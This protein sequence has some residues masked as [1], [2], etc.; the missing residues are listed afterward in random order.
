[1]T[2]AALDENTRKI[3]DAFIAELHDELVQADVLPIDAPFIAK[4]NGGELSRE[5]ITRWARQFYLTVREAPRSIGNQYVNCPD[6]ALKVEIAESIYEEE[7]G[8]I[9]GTKNHAELFRQFLRALG[10]DDDEADRTEPG[11]IAA[12]MMAREVPFKQSEE[13]FYDGLALSGLVGEG[14]MAKIAETLFHAFQKSPYNF[15]PHDLEW[16]SVHGEAD[17]EHGEVQL[18]V[19]RRLGKNAADKERIRTKLVAAA[20]FYRQAFESYK[21]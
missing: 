7:T 13:E 11:P 6:P 15:T 14:A 19:L 4:V 16:F 3:G 1:M 12:V 17:Q 8:A 10:I 9:T 18:N 20:Q 2:A 21:A 5:E